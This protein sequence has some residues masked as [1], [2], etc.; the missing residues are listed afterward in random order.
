MD[1]VRLKPP[2]G[3]GVDDVH[4][5]VSGTGMIRRERAFPLRARVCGTCGFAELFVTDPA[6]LAARWR[7]GER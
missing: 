7:A 3:G 1:G 5:V 4:A 2:S 6:G